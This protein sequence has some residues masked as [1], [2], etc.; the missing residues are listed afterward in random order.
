MTRPRAAGASS[1]HALNQWPAL[2]LAAGLGTR[3]RPLS[4][5]R[6]KPALP[7]AGLP[8]IVRTLDWLRRAGI[9]RVV[10]NLHSCAATIT[11]IVG[12]GSA[13]GVEVR[14][15]WERDVLGSAGGPARRRK[16]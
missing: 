4:S 3:L 16:G 1:G 15:S 13:F 12:D 5:V 14:Y 10:I 2:I 11:R 6:A 9:T 7:I 8:L